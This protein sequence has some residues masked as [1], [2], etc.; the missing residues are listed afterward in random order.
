[1]KISAP[2][3]WWLRREAPS[4]TLGKPSLDLPKI[5][6]IHLF[7]SRV[8][9]DKFHVTKLYGYRKWVSDPYGLTGKVQ[10]INPTWN[11]E[12]FDPFVPE[13]VSSYCDRDIEHLSEVIPS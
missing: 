9:F 1:V 4:E 7:L 12:D 10:A 13:G 3:A 5:F 6:E 2:G 8:N 11:M